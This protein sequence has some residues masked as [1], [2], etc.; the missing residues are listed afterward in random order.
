MTELALVDEETRQAVRLVVEEAR[1]L[2]E[3]RLR[4]WLGLFTDDGIYTLPMT[5]TEDPAR[6]PSLLHD[7]AVARKQRVDR[8][9][10]GPAYA[11]LPA[12]RTVHQLTNFE[13]AVAADGGVRVDCVLVVHEVR[14]AVSGLQRLGRERTL[15]GRARYSLRQEGGALRIA[16]KQVELISS[17]VAVDNLTFMI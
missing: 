4:E 16:E 12:S 3:G 15:A 14:P 5:T 10:H 17:D 1:L 6:T 9:L 2:D 13:A 7:D 11:Q 8:L